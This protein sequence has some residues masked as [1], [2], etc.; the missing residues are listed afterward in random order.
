MKRSQMK[1][2]LTL[3]LK[4]LEGCKLNSEVS[5]EIIKMFEAAVPHLANEWDAAYRTRGGYNRKPK[6]YNG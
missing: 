1:R 6:A 2:K 4:T 5:E 3:R